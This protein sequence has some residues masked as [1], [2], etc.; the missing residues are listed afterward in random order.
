MAISKWF[1]WPKKQREPM[2]AETAAATLMFQCDK[3]EDLSEFP[4]LSE[5]QVQA[6]GDLSYLTKVAFVLHWLNAAAQRAQ[7]MERAQTILTL[8][9]IIFDP[10][11]FKEGRGDDNEQ[12][13]KYFATL[14]A[15][16]FELLDFV[17][18]TSTD[19]PDYCPR[20]M[21][22]C[23]VWLAR[24]D[25]SESTSRLISDRYGVP[26]TAILLGELANLRRTLA[27]TMENA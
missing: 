9:Q 14:A 4:D 3:R 6:I 2:S 7:F 10:E 23:R 18:R 19:H 20:M 1:K 25:G 22:W 13:A 8:F 12:S 21:E 24:I 15:D 16:T 26:L 27:S 17:E 5:A 11:S